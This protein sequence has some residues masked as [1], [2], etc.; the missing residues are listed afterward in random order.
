MTYKK[1]KKAVTRKPKAIK[2]PK[3]AKM[4]QKGYKAMMTGMMSSSK[5]RHKVL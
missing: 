5:A 1:G 2:E 3:E 4:P